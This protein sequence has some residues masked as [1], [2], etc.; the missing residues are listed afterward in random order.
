M[1]IKIKKGRIPIFLLIA[2]IGAGITASGV[3][4][5]VA[6]IKLLPLYVSLA[7]MFFSS[8]GRRIAPLIGSINSLLYAFVDFSYGLYATALS[9]VLISFTLQMATFILWTKRKDGA[10]TRFRTMKWRYRILLVLGMAVVYVPC[11]YVNTNAGAT[12]APLDTFSL[13]NG[14]VCPVLTLFAFTE[15]TVFTLVGAVVTLIMNITM[16]EA[17]PDRLPYLI[18][19]VYS[20]ICCAIATVNVWRIYKDQLTR[21]KTEEETNATEI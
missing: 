2:L 7:I 17:M 18:F 8:E 5:H 1:K 12:A 10:T 15:Y 13:V 3:L 21:F 16:L 4:Y 20:L 11:L 9:D 14:F 6:F 19:S